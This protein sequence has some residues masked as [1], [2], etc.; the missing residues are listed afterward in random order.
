[1]HN[2]ERS[3]LDTLVLCLFG[4]GSLGAAGGVLHLPPGCSKFLKS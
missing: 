4:S 2:Q 3:V 1:M